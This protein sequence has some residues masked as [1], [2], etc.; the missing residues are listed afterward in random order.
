VLSLLDYSLGMG[1]WWFQTFE[2]RCLNPDGSIYRQQ[3]VRRTLAG[4]MIAWG[5]GV[6]YYDN[7]LKLS[8]GLTHSTAFGGKVRFRKH[9]FWLEDG[10]SVSL[11]EWM[12]HV[13]GPDIEGCYDPAWEK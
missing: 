12:R 6:E 8:E 1:H 11:A 5:Q 4:Y 13:F 7:G 10:T 3:I 2:Y 9:R